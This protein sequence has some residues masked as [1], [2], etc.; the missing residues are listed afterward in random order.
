MI[1][2]KRFQ[3]KINNNEYEIK[4][5][6]KGL[7]DPI[8]IFVNNKLIV[9]PKKV[10]ML[11]SY[12][13]GVHGLLKIDGEKVVF[14]IKNNTIDIAVDG[15]FKESEKKCYF[16]EKNNYKIAYLY[17]ILSWITIIV[18]ENISAFILGLV[19]YIMYLRIQINETY[20]KHK[21]NILSILVLIIHWSIIVLYKLLY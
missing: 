1:K 7:T 19:V 6:I 15:Y 18:F 16:D 11:N 20:S 10:T 12:L 21:K 13:T 14:M 3:I 17:S 8:D 2:E 4:F 9:L 5:I